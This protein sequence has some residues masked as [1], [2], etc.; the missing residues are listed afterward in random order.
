MP[1]THHVFCLHHL[2]GNVSTNVVALGSDF[3]NF[4]HDFWATYRAVSLNEFQH[5][6]DHLVAHYFAARQYHDEE[7][8]PC[9]KQWAWAWIS[10]IFI[11]VSGQ[12]AIVRSKIVSQNVL[13][14]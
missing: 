13:V 8:Y 9:C 5:L 3:A 11:E 14:D 2:S 10:F 1:L 6:Y 12:M 4:N 7:L